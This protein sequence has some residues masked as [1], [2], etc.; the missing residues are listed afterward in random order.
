M[1]VANWSGRF[2]ESLTF[3][4]LIIIFDVWIIC[5]SWFSFFI[6]IKNTLFF[7]II[8]KRKLRISWTHRLVMIIAI[9]LP[10]S[11]VLVNLMK[12]S[13][14][15]S[16]NWSKGFF[17]IWDLI[18]LKWR[19]YFKKRFQFPFCLI[20]AKIMSFFKII[21]RASLIYA[22]LLIMNL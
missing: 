17:K 8:L 9:I 3:F 21:F 7:F 6:R 1:F 12:F 10:N 22:W 13:F 19:I 2:W 15:C 18:R 5:R 20:R 4:T 11:G 14:F 16:D